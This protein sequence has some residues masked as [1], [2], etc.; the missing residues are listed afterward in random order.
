MAQYYGAVPIPHSSF[1]VWA[2]NT[3]GNGYDYDNHYGNQ[4]WDYLAEL[5][6]QYG[7]YLV[8]RQGG[9]GHAYE[10]WT[11]SK[12]VNARPPFI[13]ISDLTQM[14][15][16]DIVVFGTAWSSDGHIAIA[17]EDYN[18]AKTK[19]NFLGQNQGQGTSA[20]VNIAELSYSNAIGIFRNTDWSGV[21]PEPIEKKKKKKFPWVIAWS[22]WGY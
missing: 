16:G 20:G 15:R 22:S 7:L 5:W 14:K 3:L 2:S 12:D 17:N 13:A 19:F 10:C 1:D 6:Y 8:T 21:P 9:N 11:V 4:C 18:P